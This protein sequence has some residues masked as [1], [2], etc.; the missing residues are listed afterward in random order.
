MQEVKCD[1]L[2]I[3]IQGNNTT[4][5]GLYFKYLDKASF[6][7]EAKERQEMEVPIP[8]MNN[9]YAFMNPI[10]S[11]VNNEYLD[12]FIFHYNLLNEPL[13]FYHLVP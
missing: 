3:R 2:D 12:V 5:K 13:K 10:L 1:T 9:R 11:C 8:V 7:L 4:N 6:P